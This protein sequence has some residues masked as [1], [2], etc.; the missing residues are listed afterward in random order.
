M[1]RTWFYAGVF[2]I[3]AATLMLQL[4]ETR[5]LSVVLWYH[6]AFFAI[7]MA[8]FG[9][10]AGAV[11][12]YLRRERYTQATM[13]YDLAYFSSAMAV[14][15]VL[16]LIVQMTLALTVTLSLTGL[17]VWV[18]LAAAMA[19]PYF[20]SGIAISLA[21]TRSPFPIGQVYG[22]DLFG[23]AVGCLGVLLLLNLTDG[24]S[25]VIWVGALAAGGAL[26]FAGSGLGGCPLKKPRLASWLQRRKTLLAL[27]V[28]GALAN[29]QTIY[30]LHPLMVKDHLE[31]RDPARLE[32]WNSFSR[33]SV[34]LNTLQEAPQLWGPS[35]KLPP[36]LKVE[37]KYMEI[38]GFS[39]TSMYRFTGN[40][41]EVNFLK[42]DVTNLAYF[43]PALKRAA[44]I[45]VGGGRDILSAWAFG[46]RDITGI[47]INPVF[48]SLLTTDPRFTDFAGLHR[49][50]DLRLFVDEA[51]NW[52][53]R[54]R[55]SFD[56][57]QMTLTDTEAATGAGAF[58]LSE[59]GLY[60][61]EA[62]KT[63]LSHLTPGGVFTVSRW[64]APGQVNETGRMISLAAATLLDLGEKR[65]R[66]HIFVA[67]AQRIATLILSRSPLSPKD[68]AALEM[69]AAKYGY[70]VLASPTTPS[71]S[72]V[73]K[74]IFAATS[75]KQLERTLAPL[76]LDLSPPVDDR[77]F[78]FNQLPFYRPLQVFTMAVDRVPGGVMRGNLLA[79]ATL[80]MILLVSLALVVGTIILPLRPA[81]K[82]AG[83]RLV[84]SGSAYFFLIGIGFMTVEIALLQR[85]SVFLGHPIYS[86][87][88]VLFSL[89][90]TTGVGSLIS[91]RLPLTRTGTFALWALMTGAYLM[92]LPA[93]MPTLLAAFDHAGR[94]WRCVLCVAVVTP[95]GL[96]MGFGFPTGMRLVSAVDPNP[97]PWF[98]GINGA[99]GVLAAGA[100]VALSLAWGISTALILG[101]LCYPLLI[102]TALGIGFPERGAWLANPT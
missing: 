100:T 82:E 79:A 21:L 92:L 35:L 44:I 27:L 59:N 93:W 46:L 62:W 29:G 45:G 15:I 63:F 61:V 23:A 53:A 28:L 73:L 39:S 96:L 11:W 97:T 83:L 6:L 17:A 4:I 89:I 54:S 101:G 32:K 51:R 9:L 7:S 14:T 12:L 81:I 1:R 76:E 37:R 69:A 80:L 64:Y 98:W 68:L 48:I 57:I 10:T 60:T 18:L 71:D 42:Y 22:V 77:P 56:I 95:A 5:I 90:L 50:P 84:V 20:F 94:L 40:P 88:V 102:P 49:L 33:V 2:C 65:P 3:T 38:D 41:A 30:G 74:T 66:D 16:S 47:E 58:T 70:Q 87:S 43:I 52:F 36:G 91:D 8:M 19:V 31:G 55:E 86:L 72:P 13:S 85:M 26:C 99:A 24:P 75:R 34:F 78:F 67:A 25:A